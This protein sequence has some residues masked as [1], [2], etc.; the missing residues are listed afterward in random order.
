MA[1]WASNRSW[2]PAP[3]IAVLGFNP[4]SIILEKAAGEISGFFV[5]EEPSFSRSTI[6]QAAAF[7]KLHVNRYQILVLECDSLPNNTRHRGI[8]LILLES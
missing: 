4:S 6:S 1:E 2:K 7:K 5:S 3:L 8:D